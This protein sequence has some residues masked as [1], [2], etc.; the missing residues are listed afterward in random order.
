MDWEELD[1]LENRDKASLLRMFNGL[2]LQDVTVVRVNDAYAHLSELE[3]LKIMVVYLA[4]EKRQL[5][6]ERLK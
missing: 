6:R 3:R 4:Y 2:F 5:Q 1:C